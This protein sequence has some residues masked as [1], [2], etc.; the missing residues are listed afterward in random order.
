MQLADLAA[1][2]VT[3]GA[4]Q[5]VAGLVATELGQ[6]GAA[7]ALV[8]GI[9]EQVQALDHAA[10]LAQGARAPRGGSWLGTC[11]GCV[12]MN[13]PELERANGPQQVLPVPGDELGVDTSRR[14]EREDE[15]EGG[16]HPRL[17]VDRAYSRLIVGEGPLG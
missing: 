11:D 15:V 17:R 14:T 2:A 7:L 1:I 3:D 8:V 10:E 9:A 12:E 4:D 16:P 6:N 5:P 13:V